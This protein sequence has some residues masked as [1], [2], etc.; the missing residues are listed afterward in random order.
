MNFIIEAPDNGPIALLIFGI[1]TSIIV[2]IGIIVTIKS[3]DRQYITLR[4]LCSL[5]V[6]F[7]GLLVAP[8]LFTTYFLPIEGDTYDI[9]KFKAWVLDEYLIKLNDNQ[10]EKLL[11]N[12]FNEN[13]QEDIETTYI[14][15]LTGD[16]A[17]ATLFH[18]EDEWRLIVTE[19][20]AVPSN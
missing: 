13:D 3:V 12:T 6:V 20:I 8:P 2:V 4:G 7:V 19:S 15:T 18:D 9:K 14:T 11:D 10:A 1:L 17:L 16:D 5:G